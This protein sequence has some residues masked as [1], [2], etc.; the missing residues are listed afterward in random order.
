MSKWLLHGLYV[1]LLVA[2][3]ASLPYAMR[4]YEPIQ[5]NNIA[6]QALE[7][8]QYD[9]AIEYLSQARDAKPDDPVI[10]HNLAVAF[11]SKALD[12]EQQGKEA[13]AIAFYERALAIEPD[14]AIVVRNLVATLNNLGVAHSKS[15]EF[16]KA[17]QFFEQA[18]K[19]L[20]KLQDESIGQSI[21]SNYAGLLT[22]W[23]SELLKANKLDSA[24]ETFRQA[25]ALNPKNA[26]AMIYLGDIAYDIN[27]YATAKQFY[28]AARNLAK[29]HGDYLDSRLSMIEK[30]SKV[31]DQLREIRDRLGRF[32]V[33]YVPYSAGVSIQDVLAMLDDAH[34]TLSQTLGLRPTR[35]VNVKIYHADDFY[36]ISALPGWATGIY[37]GKMRLKAEDMQN[38]PAQ[39]RD[40][41]FHE[42]T[43]ALLAMNI[44]Q[45]LPAWFHEGLAQLMEPQFSQN[46]REQKRMRAV[47]ANGDLTFEA[48]RDSFRDFR[49]KAEAEQ[50]YL[51][52]KYF[53][54]ALR[55]RYSAEKLRQWL[56]RMAANSEEDFD[57]AFEKVYGIALKKVQERWIAEQVR[58]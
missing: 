38:T 19:W 52:S 10:R 37:D 17:Q 50:A 29:E 8:K 23:G 35:S 2:A 53:L 16:L 40:L 41:L 58:N 3:V 25:L 48:L 21:R 32:R 13:E 42:Y 46:E 11:N 28:S 6:I 7:Q 15:Q 12:L 45:A 9:R 39:V 44:R 18:A 33:Q 47:L 36:R 49:S 31:E 1:V 51:L 20:N 55:Q 5:K 14:N 30:E 54:A 34:D 4:M 24:A 27:D 57:T 43:H 26:V 22:V 56:A